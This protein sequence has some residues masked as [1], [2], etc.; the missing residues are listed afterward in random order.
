M[1][2]SQRRILRDLG[3]WKECYKEVPTIDAWPLEDN[4]YEWHANMCAKE[5]PLKGIKFHLKINFPKDYPFNPPKIEL[6]N[7]LKHPNVFKSGRYGSTAS[8]K[9]YWICLDMIKQH[10]RS[11]R[12]GGW[13]SAYSIFSILLQ[14]QAFLIG[15]NVEQQ[16]GSVVKLDNYYTEEDIK[17]IQNDSEKFQ[18]DQGDKCEKARLSI[19]NEQEDN[20]NENDNGT[21]NGNDK[22][23]NDITEKL[24]SKV[25]EAKKDLFMN[26]N[27]FIQLYDDIEN[28]II[29]YLTIKDCI[30]FNKVCLHFC[31]II[32]RNKIFE[33]NRFGCWYHRIDLYYCQRT[34]NKMKQQ[35]KQL[36]DS[37]TESHTTT[38]GDI[39][40]NINNISSS[41]ND[42][43]SNNN[44]NNIGCNASSFENA[45]MLENMILGYGFTPQF[46]K[47]D[48]LPQNPYFID[49]LKDVKFKYGASSDIKNN[50]KFYRLFSCDVTSDLLSYD[51]FLTHSV[52][53]TVWKE[54]N[55]TH[56]LPIYINNKHGKKSMKL[57]EKIC[58]QLF[59]SASKKNYSSNIPTEYHPMMGIHLILS[60]MASLTVSVTKKCD[61][62]DR[63]NLFYSINT[64]ETYMHLYH[65]LLA[66]YNKNNT[67]QNI[68]S[69]IMNQKCANFVKDPKYRTKE[70]IPNFG[71]FKL[72]FTLYCNQNIQK[73]IAIGSEKSKNS[74]DNDGEDC[75]TEKVD[76]ENESDYSLK[77]LENMLDTI[78]DMPQQMVWNDIVYPM[79]SEAFIRKV[80]WIVKE[81]PSLKT[82]SISENKKY[83]IEK[84][85]EASK[86]RGF[87]FQYFFLNYC[88][89]INDINMT[90]MKQFEQFNDNFGCA[91]KQLPLIF[92]KFVK[93]I[94]SLN[95]IY[96]FFKIIQIKNAD[97]E[98][99]YNLLKDSCN[100]SLK[101]GYHKETT[102]THYGRYRRHRW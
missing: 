51:A 10:T 74:A 47:S 63:P 83:R 57:F 73:P 42:K 34:L 72:Y 43:N 97:E 39:D 65:M 98:F 76:V 99:V 58:L 26:D 93:K 2:S 90:P 27:M 91:N 16:G 62:N 45:S 20:D 54:T 18:C 79:I 36:Q 95:T 101:H 70:Y 78:D 102:Y 88:C 56:F 19:V 6:C 96:D 17:E 28:E 8:G 37:K 59:Q 100:L 53:N 12:Y 5:G 77:Q 71:T 84:T 80:R 67:Y 49:C 92:Q 38:T 7:Y 69:E 61:D 21:E 82:V 75:K 87:L 24:V 94:Y 3:E 81:Y 14:L 29:R 48:R 89:K 15:K 4:M 33:L 22:K 9:G 25:D 50:L 66:I 23:E 40:S 60:M 68:I 41:S 46:Y 13:T 55:F 85:W 32:R 86:K 11:D 31:K 30:M 64:I 44:S 1:Q 52:R 35:G